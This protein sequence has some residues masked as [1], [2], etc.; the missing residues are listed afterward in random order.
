NVTWPLAERRQ[1]GTPLWIAVLEPAQGQWLDTGQTA[2][3]AADGRSASGKLFHFSDNALVT[4]QPTDK[5]QPAP[6]PGPKAKDA[7]DPDDYHRNIPEP[8]VFPR[9]P[10]DGNPAK[11][12]DPARKE[13]ASRVYNQTGGQGAP[14]TLD[15][16]KEIYQAGDFETVKTL[17]E[18]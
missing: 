18:D 8:A 9:P 7:R 15:R 10:A 3:V 12:I 17:I 16:M 6:P 13:A 2:K 11:K 4:A 5:E 1:A 14:M